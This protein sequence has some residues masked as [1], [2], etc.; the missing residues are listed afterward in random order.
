[1]T[2][3]ITRL[4][5][6]VLLLGSRA[7]L[8]GYAGGTAPSATLWLQPH[9]YDKVWQAIRTSRKEAKPFKIVHIG[10]SHIKHGFVTAP[11]AQALGQRYG[12]GVEVEH[13]GINGATFQTYG[14]QEEIDRIVA[15]AP[16]LLIIS[17]GTNDSY[18]PRFSPEE[19]R[20]NM[21]ALFS[22]LRKSLP[23]LPIVLTTPPPC[24][25]ATSRRVSTFTGK[26]R[27]KRRV[28]QSTKSYTFNRHTASASRTMKYV[29]QSEGCALIDLNA[30][31]GS[32]ATAAQWLSKG[33]M[34]QDRVHYTVAGYTQQGEIIVGVL[35]D[36]IEGKTN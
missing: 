1:M 6:S 9:N 13:W 29:A 27:S 22:L 33:W 3:F 21:Q 18:T 23:Q 5:L 28:Y 24:Y 8:G 25:L 10:D 32:E 17:L 15:A 4:L 30:S 12:A 7:G 16:Q 31:I 14:V 26:G 35:I 2:R 19:L 20:A 36:A 11:I 34:H